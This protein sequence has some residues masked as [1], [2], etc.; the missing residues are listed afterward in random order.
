MGDSNGEWGALVTEDETLADQWDRYPRLPEAGD[1]AILDGFCES[2]NIT[3]D[4]L[5]RLGARMPEPH[6]LA[7]AYDSGVKFRDMVTGNRWSWMGSEWRKLKLIQHDTEPSDRVVVAEGET[8]GARLSMVYDIDVAVLPAGART[9][10]PEWAEQLKDYALVFVGLDADAA[11]EDGAAQIME[12][13]PNAMR[14]APPANDWCETEDFPP[15]PE[16][17]ERPLEQQPILAL[18][19]MLRLAVP[20]VASW[21]EQAVLPIGG[22][23]MIHGAQKSFKSYLALDM[24]AALAQGGPWAGFEFD[25]REEPVKVCVVQWEIP[26]KWYRE[27]VEAML[28]KSPDPDQLCENFM[29]WTPLTKP[30][31]AAGNQKQE[32]FMLNT[33]LHYGVQVVLFDPIRRAMGLADMNAENEVR[34]MLAFFERLNR[35]GITVVAVH[36]DNKEGSRH[37][38]GSP[39]D[40]TGSGAFP[41]DPDSIVS[42]V[43][44]R[45]EDPREGKHRN[46]YLTLRNAPAPKGRGF[47]MQADGTLL[48]APTAYGEEDTADED[49]PDI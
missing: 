22:L 2:K 21:F 36:H 47:E 49:T 29:T 40:M 10:K 1:N 42:V 34:K 26:W 20:D 38:G 28:V 14:F 5:V 18:G 31:L 13:L 32:D 30:V 43:L 48:Y 41:G 6:I 39:L 12:L 44:P 35:E 33:L 3:I 9:F 8:D 15:L 19:D 11:G 23:L 24:M 45:G 7:F 25:Q 16:R 4:S 37:G 46:I 27:R 17:I